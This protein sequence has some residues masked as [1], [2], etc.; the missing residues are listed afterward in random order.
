EPEFAQRC[1]NQIKGFG[2][3]GFP[4]SH[5]ASFALLV[6]ASSWIKCHYPDVFCAGL[7]NSQP[8]GFYAPAQIVRDAREHDVEVLPVDINFSDWDNRL[9]DV[10]G[11]RFAVRL[12]FRQVD[13]LRR[14]VMEGLESCSTS[15]SPLEGEMPDRA[16]GGE[17]VDTEPAAHPPLSAAQPPQRGRLQQDSNFQCPNLPRNFTSI[18]HIRHQTGLSI[19]VLERL[20]AADCFRSLGLDRRQALWKVRGLVSDAQLP[21]FEAANTNAL[22]PDHDVQLPQMPLSEHVVADYQTHRLSL[23]AHPMSFLR[24]DYTH[25]RI[26]SCQDL[27]STRNGQYVQIAGV[28]LVRQKPGTAKGVVFMTIEDEGGVANIIVWGKIMKRFR[29]VVMRS[30]LVLVRGKVQRQGLIIHVIASS[31]AD[32]SDDLARLSDDS[33]PPAMARA[34]EVSNQVVERPFLGKAPRQGHPRNVRIIPKSRDFH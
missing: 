20:A 8:M 11:E 15:I 3:Y 7:L 29:K 27:N 23:K 19:A 17:A 26:L 30:R 18:E 4:E 31:L 34:D 13:G 9:E 14:E 22:G 21:L 25:R 33:L 6:Y 16:E 24:E 12:G 10:D 1:F 2:E 28:V 5:A 32:L